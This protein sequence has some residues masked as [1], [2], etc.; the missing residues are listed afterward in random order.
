MFRDE[1]WI[2]GRI[3]SQ[4]EAWLDLLQL[5]DW[6]PPNRGVVTVA[7]RRLAKRWNW[8]RMVVTRF[9]KKLAG[10]RQVC[11]QANGWLIVNYRQYQSGDEP[12]A[13]PA[14]EKPKKPGKRKS[15]D[16][17]DEFEKVWADYPRKVAKASALRAYS[18]RRKEGVTIQ[19][20]HQG[21][22]KYAAS[23]NG[24]PGKFTMHCSTFFGTDRRWEEDFQP[25]KNSKY[26][27]PMQNLQDLYRDEVAEAKRLEQEP[28]PEPEPEPDDPYDFL[29]NL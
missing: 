3:F 25:G 16:F 11:E 27:P 23:R 7:V 12:P 22:L 4:Q 28:E 19:S 8:D 24:E 6:E 9:L 13:D 26:Q 15:S 14:P 1:V 21:V 10:A 18:A 17:T 29:A 5:A 2:D 20:L